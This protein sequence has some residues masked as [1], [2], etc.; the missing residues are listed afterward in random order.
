ME[1]LS[2]LLHNYGYIL[3]LGK[4]KVAATQE[5]KFLGTESRVKMA[6]FHHL[7]EQNTPRFNVTHYSSLLYFS[8]SAGTPGNHSKM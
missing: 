7:T 3:M 4:E 5:I 2:H 8:F 6:H 1:F